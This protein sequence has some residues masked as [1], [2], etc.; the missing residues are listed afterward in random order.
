MAG[1]TPAGSAVQSG[2]FICTAASVSETSS[3]LNARR[4]VSIS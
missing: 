3:A 4:P 1:G 2:S